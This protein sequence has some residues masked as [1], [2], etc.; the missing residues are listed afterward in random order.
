MRAISA[1][2]FWGSIVSG[3]LA[4]EGEW[5]QAY[6]VHSALGQGRDARPNQPD[7]Q[8]LNKVPSTHVFTLHVAGVGCVTHQRRWAATRMPAGSMVTQHTVIY[9]LG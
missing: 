5:R 4:C 9:T 7:V 8:Q 2:A 1:W 3:G 6:P